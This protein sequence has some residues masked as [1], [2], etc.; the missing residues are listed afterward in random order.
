LLGIPPDRVK[1]VMPIRPR[2][3]PASPAPAGGRHPDGDYFLSLGNVEPRK[4][5]PGLVAAYAALKS[6]RPDAP[7]LYIAGHKAWGTSEAETA[8]ALHGLSGSVFL[9]DYLPEADR[10]AYLA[11]CSVYVSSSLYEGWG[12]PLF[13][14]L[15]QGKPA[16]YHAGTSQDEFAR[17]FAVA[18]DCSDAESLSRAMEQLWMD[19][20]ERE[21]LGSALAAGFGRFLDY[22]VEGALRAALAPLLSP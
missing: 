11:H 19:A 3:L 22:D 6:R 14:A 7:P 18:A 20:R 17:G 21:R 15:A 1:V 9:T 4:N 2:A 16:I 10:A 8:I 13:E 5:Y 12:L